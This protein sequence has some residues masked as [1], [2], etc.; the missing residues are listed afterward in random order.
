MRP[1][2]V[3]TRTLAAIDRYVVDGGVHRV[4]GL[5]EGLG[6]SLRRYQTGYA[7]NYAA[8]MLVGVIVVLVL[9]LA[10]RV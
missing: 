7:R 10:T 8:T 1:G 4:A 6:Q 5:T 3:L 2:Q 9:V